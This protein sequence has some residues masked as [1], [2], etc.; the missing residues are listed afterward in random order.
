MNIFQEILDTRSMTAIG[1]MAEDALVACS[2]EAQQQTL[3]RIINAS[4]LDEIY[5]ICHEQLGQHDKAKELRDWLASRRDR[6]M[7]PELMDMLGL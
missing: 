3:R 4:Q 1:Y 6:R 7:D 2:D 5:A